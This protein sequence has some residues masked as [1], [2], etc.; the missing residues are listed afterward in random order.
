MN[1]SLCKEVLKKNLLFTSDDIKKLEIFAELVLN[2]NKNYNI[3]SQSSESIIWSR[4][5]LDSAQIT[6]FIDFKSNSSLADL[7]SGAGFPGIVL[8]IFNKTK[9]FHVK[10][11]EKSPVK[12]QFLRDSLKKLSIEAEVLES[13]IKNEQLH[14]HK[15]YA[16]KANQKRIDLIN[17][18]DKGIKI[19]ISFHKKNYELIGWKIVDQFQ[20]EIF[21]SLKIQDVNIKVKNNFFKI[22]PVS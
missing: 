2:F 6:K 15:S 9:D 18:D 22:P 3:I 19:T 10:L 21:F 7:G 11:Y 16:T 20:N 1:D 8:S 5:I 13:N 4:H 14:Y 12:C 17:V